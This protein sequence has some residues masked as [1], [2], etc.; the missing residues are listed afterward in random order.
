ME[1]IDEEG[2]LFGHVNVVDALV[3]LV[4]LAVVAAGVALVT[5]G[6]G[7]A[8]S[9]DGGG[10]TDIR[11]ATVAL[12]QQPTSSASAIRSGQNVTFDGSSGTVNVTD[13]HL[14]GAPDGQVNVFAR[15][16]YPEGT[17]V[18]GAPLRAGRT[19]TVVGDDYQTEAAVESVG[20]DQSTFRTEQTPVSVTTTVDAATAAAVDAGDRY[21]V[22]NH[23]LATVESVASLP[24]NGSDVR[25][26][27]LG[28]T[29]ATRV[30]G[31][32][33]QF[34]DRTLR[35]GS[36]IPLRTNAVE[37]LNGTVETVGSHDS[38]GAP[39]NV[40][41][42]V[43]WEGVRPEV[44]DGVTAGLEARHPGATARIV[45]VAT[46]PARV[47]VPT[48]AGELVVRDH[49]R[50]RDVTLTVDATARRSGSELR[51]HDRPLSDGR[52]VTLEFDSVTL[53]GTVLDF[54]TNG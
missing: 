14:T 6:G 52:Q 46:S 51:F 23:T 48:D 27:R 35:T 49:P 30:V 5:G 33:S 24:T 34:A 47:V 15:I 25:R 42:T 4:V 12:G 40:T 1:L 2:R 3:V 22:G 53:R 28:V 8:G 18:G 9:N 13:V 29:L 10:D 19:V 32:E 54:E 38:P 11:Y 50:E 31:S 41:M 45:D 17:A 21:S 39:A 26:L 37:G 20:D 43:A 7:L 16:A 44:A 36:R